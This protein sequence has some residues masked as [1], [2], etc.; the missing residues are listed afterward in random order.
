[1]ILYHYT[2]NEAFLSIIENKQ[3][4]LS[5]LKL[6]ND[7]SEGFYF[8]QLVKQFLDNKEDKKGYLGEVFYQ[9]IFEYM[10][11]KISALGISFSEKSD[12]LS[13]WRAYADDAMGVAIGFDDSKF[14]KALKNIEGTE[15]TRVLYLTEENN[16]FLKSLL[17]EILEDG[18]TKQGSSYSQ[19]EEPG[20]IILSKE[21]LKRRQEEEEGIIK[22]KIEQSLSL[23]GFL[24]RIKNP[25]Y[26]EEKEWRCFRLIIHNDLDDENH[27]LNFRIRKNM[28]VPYQFFPK[29]SFS[30]DW[31]EEIILGPKNE[32][33]I[34]VI[35]VM[36]NNNG[37]GHVRV[38]RSEGVYR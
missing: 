22:K 28:L 2:S 5:S 30:E 3:I 26:K 13:Q 32:T 9:E 6:S 24:Y 4:W 14:N 25:F 38:I 7:P 37:F 33:P 8:S 11:N 36:L 27:S 29:E 18:K 19:K 34:D 16:D 23:A 17:S 20:L 15:L 12:S 35:K 10:S 1:M 21:D 31:I